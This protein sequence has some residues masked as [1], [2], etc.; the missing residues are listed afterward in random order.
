MWM[1]LGGV[2]VVVIQKA[3]CPKRVAASLCFLSQHTLQVLY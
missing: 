1:L 3:E 2:Q